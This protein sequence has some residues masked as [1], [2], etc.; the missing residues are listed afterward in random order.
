V[1]GIVI[2]THGGIATAL[3]DT[4]VALLGESPAGLATVEI[5]EDMSRG[6]AWDA[7]VV[8]VENADLGTG[9]LV[10][11]DMFG[12]TPSTVAM[13]LLAE[14]E[15]EVITG[16]NLAMVLRALLKR[17]EHSLSSLSEDVIGYGRRNVT[18]SAQWLSPRPM[19]N[20]R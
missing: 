5:T 6:A 11:V 2:A 1:I 20:D 13:A 7:L 15:A 16:V 12:G 4:A 9:T 17:S 14:R 18:A 19:E 10:L 8:G 3:R